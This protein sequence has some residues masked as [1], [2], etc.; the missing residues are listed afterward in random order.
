MSGTQKGQAIQGPCFHGVGVALL[1][2][3]L[4]VKTGFNQFPGP[5]WLAVVRYM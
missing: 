1:R 4:C 2:R 5:V 3:A